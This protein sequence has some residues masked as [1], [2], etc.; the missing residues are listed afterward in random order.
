MQDFPHEWDVC[1]TFRCCSAKWCTSC[2]N[3]LL[4]RVTLNCPQCRSVPQMQT[5]DPTRKLLN[6][7][8]TFIKYQQGIIDHY[9]LK[10]DEL[11]EI[12][13]EHNEKKIDELSEIIIKHY[14]KKIDELSEIVEKQDDAIEHYELKIDEL[15]TTKNGQLAY[16]EELLVEKNELM[17]V[18]QEDHI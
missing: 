8:E 1:N 14:E 3:Q 12:I 4:K 16:I 15:E 17:R 5:T 18:S 7:A 10:I 6:A 2:E 9:E 11:S 13:I